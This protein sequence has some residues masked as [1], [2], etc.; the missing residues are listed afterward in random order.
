VGVQ[1]GVEGAEEAE[2]GVFGGC[3]VCG[4]E[5][6]EACW[7]LVWFRDLS[8]RRCDLTKRTRDVGKA[9]NI[10]ILNQRFVQNV[11]WGVIRAVMRHGLGL[12]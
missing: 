5:T 12:E 9:L 11:A 10:K 3:V 4:G 1:G 7:G 6:G 2:D 8:V